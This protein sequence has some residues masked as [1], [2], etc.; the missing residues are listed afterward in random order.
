MCI[1][2]ISYR[3]HPRYSLIV[4]AN[5][6][7]LYERPSAPA[8]FWPDHPGVFAGRDLREGGTW[9]GMTTGGRF[10]ALTNVRDLARLKKEAPS[11]GLLVRDFLCGDEHPLSCLERLKARSDRYSGYNIIVG[12][13]EG[14]FY[15]SNLKDSV[16]Q[17]RPGSYG[18]SNHFLDTPWPKVRLARERLDR[19]MAGGEEPSPEDIF[20]ILADRSKP[21]D[22]DLP[23]T[24]VGLVWERILSSVFVRTEGYGTRSSTVIF[25]EHG[26]NVRFIERVFNGEPES[27]ETMVGKF[28]LDASALL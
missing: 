26:G 15:F 21:A 23:D 17:L 4:A 16:T 6:D 2:Y 18:L 5:R 13:R 1:L 11:R 24:G 10:A 20:H 25:V 28:M 12:N 14:F 9:L 8:G 22:A 7:E 3:S 27:Y 19:V